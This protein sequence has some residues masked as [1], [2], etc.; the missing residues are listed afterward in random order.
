[1]I[2]W[3]KN[4]WVVAITIVWLAVGVGLLCSHWLW[5]WRILEAIATWVLAAGIGVAIWQI[6]VTRRSNRQQLEES[7]RSINAQT[8]ISVFQEFRNPETVDKLRTIYNLPFTFSQSHDFEIL[9]IDKKK[10]IEYVLDRFDVIAVLVQ[11]EIIDKKLAIDAYAGVSAIRCWYKLFHYIQYVR[12][13]RGYFGD[14]IEAF[15]RLCMDYFQ[16]EG[17]QVIFTQDKESKSINLMQELNKDDFKPRTYEE[18]R[19]AR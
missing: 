9:S 17:I 18:I 2:G 14:N 10:D 13:E 12:E 15:T 1:M 4:N 11:E 16:K 7:R 3:L 19:K 8:A 5:N 6:I